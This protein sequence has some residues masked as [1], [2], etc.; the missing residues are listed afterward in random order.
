MEVKQKKVS[1]QQKHRVIDG[2]MI[3]IYIYIYGII[4]QQTLD[5]KTHWD[6]L[7]D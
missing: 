7:T 4:Q 3:S 5:A 2:D 6:A 1:S